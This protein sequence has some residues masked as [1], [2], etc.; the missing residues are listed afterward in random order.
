MA[1]SIFLNGTSS[2]G[3][4][5]IAK[6]LETILIPAYSYFSV[7]DYGNNWA[8][9]NPERVENLTAL[10]K[11]LGKEN[12]EVAR[13]TKDMGTEV[14]SG[15][16]ASIAEGIEKGLNYIVDHV[17]WRPS[18]NEDCISRLAQYDIILV[19][20][21]CPLKILKEREIAR[22]DRT[23]GTAEIQFPHVHKGKKYDVELHTDKSSPYECARIITDFMKARESWVPFSEK[24]FEVK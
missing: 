8:R 16:H 4:T 20:V 2:S 22:G 12:E 6:E 13:K 10:I 5:S 23:I 24:F 17:L 19:G 18:I 11:E 9:Q 14:I 3:K 1:T 7:D 21:H 15:Y